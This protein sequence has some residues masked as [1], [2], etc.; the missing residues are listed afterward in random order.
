[1]FDF[2]FSTL[3][4]KFEANEEVRELI[5]DAIITV[6]ASDENINLLKTWLTSENFQ[7]SP[8][9]KYRI[10]TK[11]FSQ[12][13]VSI[14]EKNKLRA[15]ILKGDNSDLAKYNE[16][17]CNAAVPDL[18]VKETFWKELF[19]LNCKYSCKEAQYISSGLFPYNQPKLAE[20]FFEKFCT[21]IQ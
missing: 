18:K 7:L 2:F 4:P 16:L 14:E 9:Q 19:S 6:S 13:G 21:D 3:L 1:M 15:D 20:P 5:V 8:E 12:E 10:L 17:Q 11:A